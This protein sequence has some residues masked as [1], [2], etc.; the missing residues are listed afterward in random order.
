MRTLYTRSPA[1]DRRLTELL[2][3][4]RL[5]SAYQPI[6]QLD[7][8][9]VE[10]VE[11]LLRIELDGMWLPPGPFFEQASIAGL[12][13]PLELAALAVALGGLDDLPAP[14]F[15]AVNASPST[16]LAPAFLV[17]LRNV[18]LG[19]VIIEITEKETISDYGPI[20]RLFDALRRD[21]LR[22]A[23]D[24]TGAGSSSL[25]H[26]IQLRPDV[27]KLDTSLVDQIG[28][29]HVQRALVTALVRFTADIGAT[30]I[31]EGIEQP[32]QTALLRDLGVRLGQG[33]ALGMPGP[34]TQRA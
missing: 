24:D 19:R 15:L 4:G 1:I 6:V 29:D 31:A 30:L 9:A 5:R 14:A 34:L 22:I 25:R 21:G 28:T 11:A 23:I 12:S 3:G 16:I 27:V 8:R 33:F 13:L 32:R 18:D 2:A 10:G 26:V 20:N 7:G 17:H